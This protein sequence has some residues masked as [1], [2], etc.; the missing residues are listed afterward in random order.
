M[1]S[2]TKARSRRQPTEAQKAKAAERR[3]AMRKLART[4][5]AMSQDERGAIAARLG[6]VTIEGRALSTFNAC[7]I[8]SQNPAAT[9]VGGFR[10]WLR[11]GRCVTKGERGM[12]IWVPCS[13]KRAN[14]ATEHAI[15]EDRTF[16]ILGTVFDV[17][18]TQ[19]VET[20]K[21]VA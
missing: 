1:A 7:M 12:S 19:K 3:T 17:S 6:V 4:V 11:A 16:F 20:G 5:S 10:Q 18:Q 2:L 9:V 14:D 21:A 8:W 15:G 13:E